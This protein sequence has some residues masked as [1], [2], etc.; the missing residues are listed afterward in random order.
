MPPTLATI[1][2][3]HNVDPG[4]LQCLMAFLSDNIAK[5]PE[6][7]S[8]LAAGGPR[9]QSMITE[10]VKAWHKHS[11]ELLTELYEGRTE[12]AVATRAEITKQVWTEVRQAAGLPTN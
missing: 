10:G 6:A 2:Q 4:A 5:N 7:V 12:R 3:T 1:A 11:R 9:A 8:I